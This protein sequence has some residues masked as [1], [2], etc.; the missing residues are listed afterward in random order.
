MKELQNTIQA[1]Y[2]LIMKR[3]A[4]RLIFASLSIVAIYECGK[5]VGEFVYYVLN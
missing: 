5:C 1:I 3:P 2:R 4:Y